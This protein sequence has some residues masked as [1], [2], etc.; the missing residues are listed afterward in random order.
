[1][2]I[3]KPN[4]KSKYI[5]FLLTLSAFIIMGGVIYIFEYNSLADSRYYLKKI[6][7]E[8][9]E[10][11]NKSSDLKNEIFKITDPQTLKSLAESHSL[12]PENNPKYL[13]LR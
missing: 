4:E 13:D 6:K 7:A 8:I 5:K 2:T 3:I 11:E 10:G 12:I 9:A 1:M